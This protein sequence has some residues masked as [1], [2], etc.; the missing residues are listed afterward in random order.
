MPCP[1]TAGARSKAAV[2]GD[3]IGDPYKCIAGPAIIP[4]IRFS[5]IVALL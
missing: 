1:A 3:T 2:T 5:N 4:L